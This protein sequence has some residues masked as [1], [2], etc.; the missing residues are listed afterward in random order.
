[1]NTSMVF[2]RTGSF[3]EETGLFA[4]HGRPEHFG[5]LPETI[6]AIAQSRD[7][8]EINSPLPFMDNKLRTSDKVVFI[9]KHEGYCS[10]L[11][12][13]TNSLQETLLYVNAV[14][15]TNRDISQLD[16]APD[17]LFYQ[18]HV[19]KIADRRYV[20]DWLGLLP[21]NNVLKVILKQ[22]GV[23]TK[24]TLLF[25]TGVPPSAGGRMWLVSS[26][27]FLWWAEQ[28][29]VIVD[30]GGVVDIE[31][32]MAGDKSLFLLVP[33]AVPMITGHRK[34]QQDELN[35]RILCYDKFNE[36]DYQEKTDNF[37]AELIEGKATLQTGVKLLAQLY[38][39]AQGV[40]VTMTK[41]QDFGV[42]HAL[43]LPENDEMW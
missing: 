34:L 20:T 2:G 16:V 43:A 18:A 42:E 23:A 24:R 30:E 35:P 6:R 28:S 13:F 33:N 37:L 22:Q 29:K 25:A 32:A 5:L 3:N 38:A 9:N 39:D 11:P 36:K 19:S 1:M 14:R 41:T 17:P 12:E 15:G 8:F 21:P 4:L 7:G 40:G 26:Q 10:R 31:Q 27:G